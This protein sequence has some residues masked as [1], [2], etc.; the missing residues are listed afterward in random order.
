MRCDSWK[1]IKKKTSLFDNLKEPEEPRFWNPA[2]Q[3][4]N[5]CQRKVERERGRDGGGRERERERNHWGG[6]E[7]KRKAKG[8]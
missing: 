4:R 6:G 7:E 3:T 2:N 1:S 5:P 8:K